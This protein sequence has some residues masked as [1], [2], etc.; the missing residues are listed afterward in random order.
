MNAVAQL[1]AGLAALILIAVFPAE[2]FL[3]DRPWVQKFLG[4]ESHG[5]RNV[6]LWSFCIGARNALAGV[7]T[8]VGLW[9]VRYGDETAGTTVVVVSCLYM[10]LASLFMGVADL[11]GYWRP[12]GGSVRGTIASS[13]LP[14]VA[15]I[16]I[17]A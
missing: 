4:I 7:G 8:L 3:I 13:V 6:H 2:A 5:I 10:L 11:L 16:A 9:M 17:A 14:A 15:L 1:A 12:R